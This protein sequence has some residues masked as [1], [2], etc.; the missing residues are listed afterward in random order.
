MPPYDEGGRGTPA[1]PTVLL[2]PGVGGPMGTKPG[3]QGPFNIT[4]GIT[5]LAAAGG[6]DDSSDSVGVA[7]SGRSASS[8]LKNERCG[9]MPSVREMFDSGR[10]CV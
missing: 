9:S 4:E 8:A 10:D 5:G 6:S 2:P 3:G 1:G 7:G